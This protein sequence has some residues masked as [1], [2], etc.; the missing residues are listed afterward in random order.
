MNTAKKLSKQ[1][2]TFLILLFCLSP[3]SHAGIR[4]IALFEGKAFVSID[5]RNVMLKAGA[6]DKASG[7]TLVSANSTGAVIKDA[8][9]QKR[10]MSLGPASIPLSYDSSGSKV[11]SKEKKKVVIP[12]SSDGHHRVTIVINGKPIK[13]MVDTGATSLAFSNRHAKSLGISTKH[14]KRIKVGTANGVTSAY[15]GKLNKVHL[16]ELVAYNVDVAV[17]DGSSPHIPLL[18]MSF[19]KNFNMQNQASDLVIETR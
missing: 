1:A 9:G 7:V 18:G 8:S 2:A 11:A 19:L 12:V 6:V 13:A 3:L 4:V 16:G 15:K 10:S 5:G 14:F 17:L